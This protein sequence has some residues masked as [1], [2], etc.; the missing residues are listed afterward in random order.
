MI[1][2]IFMLST[3]RRREVVWPSA[4]VSLF[5]AS[6]RWTRAWEI[7]GLT[8][9]LCARKCS[10]RPSRA[11]RSSTDALP[12]SRGGPVSPR[13]PYSPTPLALGRGRRQDTRTRLPILCVKG[14]ARMLYQYTSLDKK[15]YVPAQNLEA[16]PDRPWSWS[17]RPREFGFQRCVR[18]GAEV[19]GRMRRAGPG[20]NDG[21]RGRGRVASYTQ[22]TQLQR[23]TN[24]QNRNGVI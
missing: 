22:V 10:A 17:C 3:L 11:F 23:G 18:R 19:G 8:I 2:L 4:G 6:L 16:Q 15:M 21:V 7:R 13:S 24:R 12:F 9:E 1:R 5:F 20:M 14:R